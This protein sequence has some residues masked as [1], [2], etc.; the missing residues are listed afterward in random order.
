[1]V[2]PDQRKRFNAYLD[3]VARAKPP[4]TA[5]TFADL[6][7]AKKYSMEAPAA[8]TGPLRKNL[9]P[10]ISGP[11]PGPEGQRAAPIEAPPHVPATTPLLGLTAAALRLDCHRRTVRAYIRAGLLPGLFLAGRWKIRSEDL[12]AFIEAA[13]R[14]RNGLK[15]RS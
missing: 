12:E 11:T 5:P 2:T 14:A 8:P 4:G 1:M 13:A 3:A 9:A 7:N 15:P 6:W 10:A